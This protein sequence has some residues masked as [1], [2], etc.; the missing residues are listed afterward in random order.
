MVKQHETKSS[1][2]IELRFYRWTLLW[3]WYQ[4]FESGGSRPVVLVI[5]DYDNSALFKSGIIT[6]LKQLHTVLAFDI[7][8]TQKW[9]HHAHGSIMHISK[10]MGL[11]VF[12]P[13]SF[14]T[15]VLVRFIDIW[16][17]QFGILSSLLA[18]RQFDSRHWNDDRH[19][20]HLN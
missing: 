18:R 6:W 3:G 8:I 12:F 9:Y 16:T 15:Q 11:V 20:P 2:P 19:H 13:K 7:C 17:V 1:S 14:L 5:M 10:Q 4:N